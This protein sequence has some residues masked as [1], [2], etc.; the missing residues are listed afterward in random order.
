MTSLLSSGR[1]G[2][3]LTAPADKSPKGQW[4]SGLVTCQLMDM[5]VPVSVTS[6]VTHYSHTDP[7]LAALGLWAASPWNHL[8]FLGPPKLAAHL[9][10]GE[11]GI[12]SWG[13]APRVSPHPCRPPWPGPCSL[14]QL[15]SLLSGLVLEKTLPGQEGP[16]R[17]HIRWTH[18][19]G[20]GTLLSREFYSLSG[21]QT[22]YYQPFCGGLRLTGRTKRGLMTHLTSPG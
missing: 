8:A 19:P 14:L 4:T 9:G 12:F 2:G 21:G 3:Q 18:S 16:Q 5:R 17:Q 1:A 7:C 20:L 22:V 6:C 15:P 13:L 10:E 11:A